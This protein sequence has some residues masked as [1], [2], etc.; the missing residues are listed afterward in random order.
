M[1]TLVCPA[2]SNTPCLCQKSGIYR[3]NRVG[4]S[5]ALSPNG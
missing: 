5:V 3:P 1:L 4:M 2:A